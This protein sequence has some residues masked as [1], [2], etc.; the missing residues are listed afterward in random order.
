[1]SNTLRRSAASP[2]V[3]RSNSRVPSPARPSSRATRLLRGLSRPLPLPCANSTR[4]R[5]GAGRT[6]TPSSPTGP[7][8]TA[9]PGRP[10]SDV[11]TSASRGLF[12]G[13]GLL[14]P[15]HGLRPEPPDAP[16]PPGGPSGGPVP[17]GP[18]PGLRPEPPDV[19]GQRLPHLL[20]LA[21][22]DVPGDDAEHGPGGVPRVGRA[23]AP[24]PGRD[25]L[26]E[27]RLA[28]LAARLRARAPL[29]V[30]D[31]A[32]QERELRAQVRRQLQGQPVPERVQHRA[33]DAVGALA[34][35][36]QPGRD[37]VEPSVGGLEC[38]VE[39]LEAGGAHGSL[40]AGI[41][42]GVAPPGTP[43]RDMSLLPAKRT[44]PERVLRSAPP[45][46]VL[47]RPVSRS[48]PGRLTALPALAE[49][50]P[51]ARPVAPAATGGRRRRLGGTGRHDGAF[52]AR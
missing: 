6:S 48:G 41:P 34:V 16:P 33:Q 50:P 39:D 19:L 9:S 45:D 44:P 46:L 5:P 26:E 31:A 7:I 28:A 18:R 35:R 24:E 2:G 12:A 21:L 47:P 3:S 22:G 25:V 29:V 32:H 14:R 51:A 20:D 42:A 23:D 40:R 36:S 43:S 1:M 17:R 49:E 37:L 27:L 30:V 10:A 38:L 11:G 8:R 52:P 15:R 13:R 4:P